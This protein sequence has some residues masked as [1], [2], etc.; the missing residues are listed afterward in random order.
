MHSSLNNRY[1][2]PN[3]RLNQTLNL[4]DSLLNI[5]SSSHSLNKGDQ[6]L[7]NRHSL[8]NP[9]NTSFVTILRE[10]RSQQQ[11]FNSNPDVNNANPREGLV[12]LMDSND[13]R[14][15]APVQQVPQPNMR[16]SFN[17]SMLRLSINEESGHPQNMRGSL[18][19]DTM[20][21]NRHSLNLSRQSDNTHSNSQLQTVT[22]NQGYNDYNQNG[23]SMNRTSSQ[24]N[25][26][27]LRHSL[28]SE[29]F[30]NQNNNRDFSIKD[31]V[32]M[33]KDRMMNHQVN[34]PTHLTHPNTGIPM[35]R[36][37]SGH[38][39]SVLMLQ[40][41]LQEIAHSQQLN[42][43]QHH[44]H[45]SLKQQSVSRSSLTEGLP[46]HY[47]EMP[48]EQSFNNPGIVLQNNDISLMA[49][50]YEEMRG[51]NHSGSKPA[52]QQPSKSEGIQRSVS[53]KD[54]KENIYLDSSVAG[55]HDNN[56]LSARKSINLER[57]HYQTSRSKPQKSA[58]KSRKS[59]GIK[60]V[61][62]AEHNN[63]HIEVSKWLKHIDLNDQ[64]PSGNNTQQSQ[65]DRNGHVTP[66]IIPN[67]HQ[68]IH[69]DINTVYIQNPHPQQIVAVKQ[70]YVQHV[71][72][73]P[74]SRPNQQ[75]HLVYSTQPV[76]N[77]QVNDYA[78]VP[79]Q[80]IYQF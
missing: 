18:Q 52:N 10:S 39:G 25:G 24:G 79:A 41:P 63:E 2:L 47:V 70:D 54:L 49:S 77:S 45:D 43:N 31:S 34:H 20:Q 17:E 12:T 55:N 44:P 26:V 28:Q 14:K 53:Y 78:R 32:V 21:G 62:I 23:R 27:N 80:R 68:V 15:K 37:D 13:F 74:N 22:L 9:L 73:M 75:M 6:Q 4:H 69:H 57:S 7:M 61:T 5:S 19:Q 67:T 46:A 38:I 11:G 48:R 16:S 42:L 33:I 36:R 71:H 40:N 56:D 65:D 1:T 50:H 8:D 51:V 30:L 59:T 72:H 29:H 66:F 58:M 3:P 60:K 35:N 76:Y 64:S